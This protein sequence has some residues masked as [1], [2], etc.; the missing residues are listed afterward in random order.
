MNLRT[1]LLL[2]FVALALV[3]LVALSAFSYWSGLRSVDGLVREASEERASL[4]ARRV[5]NLLDSQEKRLTLLARV[6]LLRDYVRDSQQPAPVGAQPLDA[7]AA[8]PQVPL[9]PFDF[10]YKANRAYIESITILDAAGRPLFRLSGGDNGEVI[11]QTNN[12]AAGSLRYDKSVW[13]LTSARLL[14]SPL[15]HEGMHGSILS[16]TIPIFVGAEGSPPS[17]ALVAEIKMKEI[18]G[19]AALAATQPASASAIGEAAPSSRR[20][21]IFAIDNDNGRIIYHTD[22]HSDISPWRKRCPISR[23]WPGGCARA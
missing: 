22:P 3:P 9:E 2:I 1:K 4:I 16:T 20:H 17:G 6:S 18:L 12:I 15:A 10:F 13:G 11:F 21:V 7:P 5:E 8:G 14:R 19:D 23:G